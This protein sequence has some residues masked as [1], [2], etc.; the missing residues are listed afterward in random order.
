MASSTVKQLNATKG[1]ALIRPEVFACY[2]GLAEGAKVGY[3][4]LTGRSDKV[5]TENLRVS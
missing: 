4:F 1:Y 3:E 2:N 5:A